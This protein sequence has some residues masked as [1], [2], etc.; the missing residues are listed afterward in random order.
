M[1]QLGFDFNS[2]YTD[3]TGEIPVPAVFVIEKDGI[4]SF[5]K[6]LGGDYRNRVEAAMILAALS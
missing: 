3:N 6:S 1:S 5:A 4:I 2:F